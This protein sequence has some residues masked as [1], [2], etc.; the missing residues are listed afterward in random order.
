[1]KTTNKMTKAEM[2]EK[3]TAKVQTA[4]PWVKEIFLRGLKYKT[5]A[6]LKELLQNAKVTK[7]RG[8]HLV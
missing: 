7:G 5:K 2:I 4:H 6:E 8:I 3:L 1:M